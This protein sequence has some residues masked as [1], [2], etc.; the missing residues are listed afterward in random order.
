MIR[1]AR[2]VRLV[3]DACAVVA[4]V[5]LA[6][7]V[8]IVCYM[9]MRRILGHSSYWEV[10]ASIYLAVA[11]TFLASPYTLRT[12][13]YAAVY[14]VPK[15]LPARAAQPWLT[16]V[17]VLG[18][19]VCLYLAWEGWRLT[20]EALLADERS[21]SMWRPPRWP[22]YAMMPIGM[23][24]TALQYVAEILVPTP[25]TAEKELEARGAGT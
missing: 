9:V 6:L 11:A 13:G 25:M 1:F 20:H 15:V 2:A 23:G 10:E 3:S 17:R 21:I 19:L 4:S 12:H 5:L 18:L 24:L 22:L 16:G 8:V 14:Y 7:S